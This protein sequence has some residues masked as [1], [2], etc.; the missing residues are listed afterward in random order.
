M[1]VLRTLMLTIRM[2]FLRVL[3]SKRMLVM[4]LLALIPAV[5]VLVAGH[6]WGGAGQAA[7]LV[8]GVWFLLLQVV[9]PLVS[10]LGGSAVVAEEIADR[11]INWV[12]TR[13]VSRVGFF[14]GR[15][16]VAV[17]QVLV[18]VFL[19]FLAVYLVAPGFREGARE[20]L[21]PT[22]CFSLFGA[23]VYTTLFAA[24]GAAL[25]HPM[26]VGLG[27]AFAL[28][29]LLANLPGETAGL[30]ILHQ[31]RSLLVATDVAWHEVGQTRI[32][33]YETPAAAWT[34][35]AWVL[36]ISLALG[37]WRVRRREYGTLV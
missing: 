9:L 1:E 35:L 16:L 37:C 18:V 2:H 32:M 17:V 11:T 4:M 31:I 7:I 3:F 5:P 12:F 26:V 27:Y 24:M 6:R 15:W 30:S 23:V 22:L 21:V 14:L 13:P 10:L 28:E 25:R 20:L 33:P 19:S 36:V 29:A 8:H 34:F